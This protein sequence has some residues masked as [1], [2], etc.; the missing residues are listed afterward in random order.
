MAKPEENTAAVNWQ[1]R[2]V[3]PQKAVSIG[4]FQFGSPITEFYADVAVRTDRDRV[5][6]QASSQ[7]DASGFGFIKRIGHGQ[8]INHRNGL[9]HVELAE[10]Q[11]TETQVTMNGRQ[12]EE[13][14]R[15]KRKP[16]QQE[17]G[18]ACP[19]LGNPENVMFHVA[20]RRLTQRS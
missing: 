11:R 15:Q 2:L 20:L 13:I 17:N 4:F 12:D 9:R 3:A 7:N 1:L 19:Q 6:E 16:R 5:A 14:S 10:P 8:A 18:K